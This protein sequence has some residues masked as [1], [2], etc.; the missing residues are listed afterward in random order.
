MMN[1][2]QKRQEEVKD[3]SLKENSYLGM[4]AADL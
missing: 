3:P 1:E 2:G 4:A